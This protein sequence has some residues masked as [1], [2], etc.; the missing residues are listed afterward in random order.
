MSTASKT[1]IA[2]A[3]ISWTTCFSAPLAS[4]SSAPPSRGVLRI[5]TTPSRGPADQKDPNAGV[6]TEIVTEIVKETVRHMDF[7]P[8]IEFIP[9][10]R[11]LELATT[12]DYVGIYPGLKLPEREKSFLFSRPLYSY[13][14]KAVVLKASALKMLERKSLKGMSTCD[15]H[16][17]SVLDGLPLEI[18]RVSNSIQCLNLFRSKRVDFILLPENRFSELDSSIEYRVIPD[19]LNIA[20]SGRFLINKKYPNAESLLQEFNRVHAT[21]EKSGVWDELARRYG[22]QNLKAGHSNE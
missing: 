20:L 10:K 17:S 5:L 15:G 13:L 16:G 7:E 9:W 8:K 2:L 4:T 14:L 3:L 21:L 22:Y 19:D 11:A 6:I 18:I 1:L 12:A